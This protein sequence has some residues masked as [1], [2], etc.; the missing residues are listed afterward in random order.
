MVGT[1]LGQVSLIRIYNS[2]SNELERSE[3]LSRDKKKHTCA[4]FLLLQDVGAQSSTLASVIVV[5]KSG[6]VLS[7]S[8]GIV[9]HAPLSLLLETQSSKHCLNID[10]VG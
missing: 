2:L 4:A 9:A 3:Y 5:V 1:V 8:A 7:N 6:L 10:E